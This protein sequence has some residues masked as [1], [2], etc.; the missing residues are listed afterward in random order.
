MAVGRR[1]SEP[2]ASDAAYL[3]ALGVRIREC[4]RATGLGLE[5][6]ADRAGL[7]RTHLWK[8]EMGRLNAGVLSYVRL[9]QALAVP[10][11]TL[12]SEEDQQPGGVERDRVTVTRPA[13]QVGDRDA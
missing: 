3:Q 8:I 5:E 13:E 12:L 6:L 11:G 7:H 10:L 4:R 2:S 1:P 9:A